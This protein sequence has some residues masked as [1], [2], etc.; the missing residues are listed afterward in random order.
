MQTSSSG[1]GGTS[2][3]SIS[4]H[5]F[6]DINGNG[7]DDDGTPL[8]GFKVYLDKNNNAHFDSGEKY[9]LTDSSGNYSFGSLTAGTY[10]V[11]ETLPTGWK[12][13]SSTGK[14][15]VV[16]SSG[17]N[18]TNKDFGLMQ[19]TGSSS[20]GGTSL[21]SISGHLFNDTNGNGKDD[22]GG[23]L[24]GFKVYLDKNNNAHF[25]SGEKYTLTD[26]KGNYSFSSL[27]AGTYYVREVLPSGYRRTSSTG[28]YTVV[29]SSGV[30]GTHKD[31]GLTNTA[32]LN[33]YVFNDKNSNDKQ[34]SG[35][36]GIQGFKIYLDSNNNGKL[37]SG[38]RYADTDK[39]GYWVFKNLKHGKYVVRI[40]SRSGY[41]TIG[42]SSI[43]MSMA[44]GGS[45]T[46]RLFAEHVA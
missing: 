30:N 32:L 26:S 38:E 2:L 39:D 12:R 43:S 19:T 44:S 23:P 31:F 15:T 9:T 18:G 35:E 17:I 42:R 20:G 1:G 29:L 8:V 37:D 10:Y 11:R 5:L 6:N 40:Q 36:G 14:Y 41:K 28:K 21:S 34:D 33:G 24:V 4:G 16:L 45:Y 13:T 7:K 25:D 27:T 3:S 46:G 22:E